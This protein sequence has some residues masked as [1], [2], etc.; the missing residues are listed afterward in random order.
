M[1]IIL[2]GW[3]IVTLCINLKH[4]QTSVEVEKGTSLQ[5]L[6]T[7]IEKEFEAPITLA[8]VNGKLKEL[9][10]CLSESCEV[11]FLDIS[12]KDGYRTYQRS[13]TFLFI[14]SLRDVYRQH[15]LEE[16]DV[17]IHFTIQ[18]GLYC[19]VI[20]NEG[21]TLTPE[22]I[23]RV[24]QQMKQYVDED[25]PIVKHTVKTQEAIEL[26]EQQGMTDK[27][28]LLKYRSVSNTNIYALD[29]YYDY[30]F[31]YMIPSCGGL[32]S[33]GLYAH[34][35]GIM[36]QYVSK[37]EPKKVA[38]FN[39]ARLLFDT[40]KETSRWAELMGV[41]TVGELNQLIATGAMND[42][43]LVAEA[44]MEKR[45]ATIADQIV[46]H[47]QEK[48]FIFIAGPSSSGKTTFA[49]RLGI[50]L[51]A[52]GMV[53][54]TI[55]LD[56]YFVNREDTPLDEFGNYNFETIDAIDRKLFNEHMMALLD[57][58]LVDLPHY[59]FI[60]GKREYHNNPI[61]LGSKGIFIIE[62]I[63]GLNDNL[64]YG[65]PR[66]NQYKIYI[67]AMTQLNLDY[68]NRIPTTDG[69]L[70]RRIVRDYQYRGVSALQTIRMWESVRRG[71]EE[72]IFPFQEKADVMFNSALIYEIAVLKQYADPL[73]YSIP[74]HCPEHIEAKRLIKFLDYILGVTSE[75]IPQNSL[76]R[77][78]LGG[79]CFRT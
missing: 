28:T 77:E 48:R 62:G 21:K 30:Y 45:I 27:V 18:C 41:T 3:F 34:D 72:Y 60:S 36:I 65:L 79:S 39:P 61:E 50:Q 5:T 11:E 70:L 8:I 24:E 33:F 56:N 29:G 46:H 69:R 76:I 66:E 17:R 42:L 51:R 12:N 25:T 59:N 22:M 58:Q 47:A 15:G 71:E 43:I 64:T 16:V 40:Q 74:E 44:L 78:F 73:L 26:F 19:E 13:L 54:K 6:A 55:S 10:Y 14:K 63:H 67:S 7:Q 53:P 20:E 31:G 1:N 2:G 38:D 23:Q 37:S 68:H 52:Y 35:E 9:H 4:N 49:H 75:H 32:K 57:G